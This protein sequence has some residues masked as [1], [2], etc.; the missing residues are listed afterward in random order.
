[1]QFALSAEA[2]PVGIRS[3]GN[4]WKLE[5]GAFKGDINPPYYTYSVEWEILNVIELGCNIKY[6]RDINCTNNSQGYETTVRT[7]RAVVV[8]TDS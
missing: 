3:R 2:R 5:H 1:M 7:A 8:N 4:A 6:T